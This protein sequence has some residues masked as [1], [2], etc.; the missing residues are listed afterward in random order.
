MKKE[1]II[2]LVLSLAFTIQHVT[3]QDTFSIVAVDVQTGEVG[4]AGASCVDL[5]QTNLSDDDFLGEL[6]PQCWSNKYPGL[7]FGSES[8]QCNQ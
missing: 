4:S 3:C 6:I 7:L 2:P 5:F 8:K 1:M